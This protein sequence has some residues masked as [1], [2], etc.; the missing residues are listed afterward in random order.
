MSSAATAADPHQ[1]VQESV[2]L[3]AG[4]HGQIHPVLVATRV[5]AICHVRIDDLLKNVLGARQPAFCADNDECR[6]LVYSL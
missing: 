5:D 3:V 2:S 4:F 1:R 6:W